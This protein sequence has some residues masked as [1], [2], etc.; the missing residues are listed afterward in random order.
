MILVKIYCM[1]VFTVALFLD[2]FSEKWKSRLTNICLAWLALSI[3]LIIKY[4]GY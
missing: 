2:V 1:I 3:M 4:L